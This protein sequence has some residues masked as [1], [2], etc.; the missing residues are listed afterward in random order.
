MFEALKATLGPYAVEAK[1]QA[2]E[3]ERPGTEALSP[4]LEAFTLPRRLVFFDE[5]AVPAISPHV[6]K[7]VTGDGSISYRR[8]HENLR[9]GQRATATPLIACNPD[10]TN[11]PKLSLQDR[12][13]ASRFREL[14]YPAIP[15]S[16]VDPKFS[17]IIRTPEFRRAFLVRLVTAAAAE[18]PGHPPPAPKVVREATD[19]RIK[20]EIGEI[21][22]FARRFVPDGDG[23][24]SVNEAWMEW[25]RQNAEPTN[26]KNPGGIGKRRLSTELRAHV[27]GL[28]T[29]KQMKLGGKNVR[30]WTGW[31]LRTLEELHAQEAELPLW[32]DWDKFHKIFG[33]VEA[34]DTEERGTGP[35]KGGRCEDTGPDPERKKP[36][37]RSILDLAV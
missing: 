37:S 29:P 1:D 28:P 34:A 36:D 24:I 2:F 23:R 6:F 16:T 31:R 7:R 33:K 10:P 20:A 11:L 5:I 25:C 32:C 9:T 12:A 17:Q 35:H 3:V 8:L 19:D 27:R 13:V 15:E 14:P 30:G 4:A 22:E 26:S 21:G 18:T